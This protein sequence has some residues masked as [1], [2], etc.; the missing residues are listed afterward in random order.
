MK[1]FKAKAK[2]HVKKKP[3]T[4]SVQSTSWILEKAMKFAKQFSRPEQSV[5]KR[6]IS[7]EKW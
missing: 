4:G 5:E 1:Y 7:L 2:T 6:G 3:H